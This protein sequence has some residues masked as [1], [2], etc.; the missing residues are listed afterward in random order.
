VVAYKT[1]A[2]SRR[3]AKS[4]K[5][6][7]WVNS[8]KQPALVNQ[9]PPSLLTT[10]DDAAGPSS[11]VTPSNE[12]GPSKVF[13]RLINR[14]EEKLRNSLFQNIDS[15]PSKLQKTRANTAALGLLSSKQTTRDKN[16]ISTGY[17]MIDMEL[18]KEQ[19]MGFFVCKNCLK[20]CSKFEILTNPSS[21]HGL[22]S[23]K[24]DYKMYKL[25]TRARIFYQLPCS[26]WR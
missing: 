19:L 18:L 22:T 8:H 26:K 20:N 15:S 21:R 14:S 25:F 2:K 17:K 13:K 23:G 9:Q 12:P 24:N 10:E 4:R 5:G 3:T 6:K 1:I 7:C 16:V 11:S